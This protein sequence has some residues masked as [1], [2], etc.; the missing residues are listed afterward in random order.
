MATLQESM[1]LGTF[2]RTRIVDE[3]DGA[4]NADDI[5]DTLNTIKRF[6]GLLVPQCPAFSCLYLRCI[7][8]SRSI[9]P[10]ESIK[11]R[12]G[13]ASTARC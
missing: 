5:L 11:G 12:N 10:C 7:G 13:A 4:D 6:D 3:F 2:G 1:F 9:T 8:V